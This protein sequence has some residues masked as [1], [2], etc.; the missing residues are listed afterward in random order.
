MDSKD[1][2]V[3]DAAL[4]LV[5]ALGPD[6]IQLAPPDEHHF[7]S[8]QVAEAVAYGML[9]LVGSGIAAGV[10]DWTRDKTVNVLDAVA[11]HI[12]RRLPAALR[13]P[14]SHVQTPETSD[15]DEREACLN[16][17]SAQAATAGLDPATADAVISVGTAAARAVLEEMG[18]DS[19]LSERV[20]D[21]L[22]RQLVTIIRQ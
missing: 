6:F 17:S 5:D 18:V 11:A 3:E 15:A 13:K 9:G 12:S 8:M 22:R 16:V 10:K 4:A 7:D 21:E 1:L 20:H 19:S 2:E 14:F